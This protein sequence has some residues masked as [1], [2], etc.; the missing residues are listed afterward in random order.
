MITVFDCDKTRASCKSEKIF[1]FDAFDLRLSGGAETNWQIIP[2]QADDF[3]EESVL[4][5]IVR[6]S[7]GDERIGNIPKKKKQKLRPENCKKITAKNVSRF[8]LN[9]HQPV[10][11]VKRCYSF[12]TGI[13]SNNQP[14][15]ACVIRSSGTRHWQKNKRAMIA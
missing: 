10:C 15:P 11:V 2:E 13:S 4:A 14:Y 5:Q 6:S 9:T 7:K 8:D 3:G 1:P 12:V